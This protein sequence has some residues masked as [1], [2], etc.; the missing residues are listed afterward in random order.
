[1]C[2][3]ARRH[4]APGVRPHGEAARLSRSRTAPPRCDKAK[5]RQEHVEAQTV[6]IEGVSINSG[7]CEAFD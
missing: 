4:K 7:K 2:A 1:M 3:A 6:E 5:R